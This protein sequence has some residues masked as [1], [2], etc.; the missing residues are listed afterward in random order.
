MR[1][2]RI[3]EDS[4]YRQVIGVGGLGTGMFFALDGEHTLGRNESR[5]GKLLNVRDY[6]KLHI[7]SHYIAKL[8]GASVQGPFRVLPVG[9]VGDDASGDFVRKELSTAGIDTQLVSSVPGRPTLFSVCFQYPD[10]S[11]GNIT[12]SNSVASEMNEDDLRMAAE[13]LGQNG[14]RTIALILPEVPLE[15]RQSFL[16]MA[17]AAGSLCVGSFIGGE[18]RRALAA[19][20]FLQLDLVSLNEE[21][22]SEFVGQEFTPHAPDEFIAGAQQVLRKSY[23]K[24]RLVISVGKSGAYALDS[25]GWNYCPAP[26]VNVASTA[27]AGDSLLAGVVSAMAAKVPLLD[28]SPR[29]R[30]WNGRQLRTALDLGVLLASYKVT[31]AH[32]IHP[33]ASLSPLLEFADSMRVT[34]GGVLLQAVGDAVESR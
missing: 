24:L 26:E 9:K 23:P 21:E 11:G 27:G 17:S 19:G 4:P 34:F 14:T 8:L 28:D 1:T 7:V 12:T 29:T 32:T 30:T 16:R 20:M 31:S 3:G 5:A 15:I 22:A 2:L 18:V 10:G 13:V 6:C 25:D 33:D